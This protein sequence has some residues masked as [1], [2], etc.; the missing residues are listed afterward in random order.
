MVAWLLSARCMG[1]RKRQEG[2]WTRNERDTKSE[3]LQWD[4]SQANQV[5]RRLAS[6]WMAEIKITQARSG[7]VSMAAEPRAETTVLRMQPW[8]FHHSRRPSRRLEP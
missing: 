3:G 6:C 4:D 8:R 1:E 2:P 7:S 5:W